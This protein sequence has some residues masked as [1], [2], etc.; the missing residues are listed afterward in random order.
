VSC[1]RTVPGNSDRINAFYNEVAHH[2][3]NRF[4]DAASARD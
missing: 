4:G 2:W 1:T 3:F